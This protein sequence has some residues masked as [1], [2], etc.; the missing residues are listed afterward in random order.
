M[1]RAGAL[2]PVKRS[3]GEAQIFTSPPRV[4]SPILPPLFSPQSRSLV[5][6]IV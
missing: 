5:Y 3:T 6:E 4:F 2:L 1:P